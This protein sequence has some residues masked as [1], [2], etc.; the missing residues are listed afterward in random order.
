MINRA[1]LRALPPLHKNCNR[2]FRRLP[3]Q[4]LPACN[5]GAYSADAS[6]ARP[7]AGSF[8]RPAQTGILQYPETFRYNTAAFQKRHA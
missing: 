1:T 8:V 7:D 3:A 5:K 2:P 4:S 6:L